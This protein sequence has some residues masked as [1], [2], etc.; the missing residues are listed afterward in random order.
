MAQTRNPNLVFSVLVLCFDA[1]LTIEL[2]DTAS[3]GSG[4][5]L[6]GVE[7]MA[8][9]ADLHMDLLLRRAGYE[10]VAAVANHLRLIILRM[11]SF[12]HFV[13]SLFYL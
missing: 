13:T 3:G 10:F 7:R 11:N 12:F 2:I 6:A 1:V 5:L 8:L 4:L 9:G